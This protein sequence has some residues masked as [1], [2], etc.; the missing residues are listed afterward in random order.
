[1][2]RSRVVIAR[3]A[4]PRTLVRIKERLGD[5]LVAEQRRFPLIMPDKLLVTHSRHPS[6]D[7]PGK[8]WY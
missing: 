8:P 1:M 3:Q 7:R 5:S 6:T 4:H 2:G